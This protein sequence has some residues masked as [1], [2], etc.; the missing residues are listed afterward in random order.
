M[1]VLP[2]SHGAWKLSERFWDT[3]LAAVCAHLLTNRLQSPPSPLHPSTVTGHMESRYKSMTSKMCHEM[4]F[5]ISTDG[6]VLCSNKIADRIRILGVCRVACAQISL[7]P[8]KFRQTRV[9]IK[10]TNYY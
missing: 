9:G 2:D 10:L 1:W 8:T 6:V 5:N 7:E 4:N 3:V